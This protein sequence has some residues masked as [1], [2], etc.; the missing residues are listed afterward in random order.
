MRILESLRS[1]RAEGMPI[2]ERLE[3]EAR[4]YIMRG[5]YDML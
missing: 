5:H 4:D 2:D 3:I 1:I